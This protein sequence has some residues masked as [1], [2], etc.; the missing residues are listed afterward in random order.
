MNTLSAKADSFF[1]HRACWRGCAQLARSR[2]ST[3]KNV[4][5]G[6]F[7]P[8]HHKTAL[9]SVNASCQRLGDV[10]A[11]RGA[12][13]AR[14]VRGHLFYFTTGSL[15]LVCEYGDE[16]R[17]CY[18]RNRSSKSVVP[19]HPLDVQAFHSNLA[20]ARDQ[21][22]GNSVLVFSAKV[23]HTSVQPVD[24]STL[25]CPVASA[26]FLA[27]E[28]SLSAPQFRQ[29]AFEKTRVGNLFSVRSR[30]ELSEPDVKTD[31]GQKVANHDWVGNFAR[32]HHEPSIGFTLKDERLDGSLKLTMQ[33]DAQGADV[34]DCQSVAFE[35]NAVAM[36]RVKDRVEPVGTFESR[37]TRFLTGFDPS[38]EVLEGLIQ[39]P[40]GTLCASRQQP[41]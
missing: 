12:D 13:L 30:C 6:I 18:V 2:P 1:E 29:F 28:R 40:Q 27:T 16:A 17:P 3:L 20:V 7:V 41:P 32:Y 10:L 8:I 14:V 23:S 33:T 4:L 38:K 34:L 19:D 24:L 9:A 31:C 36:A 22:I 39:P 11:A 37:V 21:V 15:S 26:L 5:G 35:P 25:L